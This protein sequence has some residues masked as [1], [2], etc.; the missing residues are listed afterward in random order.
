MKLRGLV[1]DDSALYRRILE[2]SLASLP[3][4]EIL[5]SAWNGRMALEK[6]RALQPDFVTLDID[7]PEMDG[8]G[9]L[10]SVR[11]GKMAVEAIIVSGMSRRSSESTVRALNRGALDFVVKP[12]EDSPEKNRER[13]KAALA[14]LVRAIGHRVEVRGLLGKTSRAQAPDVYEERAH[15]HSPGTRSSLVRPPGLVLIGVSTGGPVALAQLLRGLP[16]RLGVPILVV[17]H[18]PP[19]FTQVLAADLNTRTGLTVK[20][21]TD[22]DVAQPDAVYLAPGGNHM[23][24]RRSADGACVLQI[25]QDPPVNN[26]RPA[27][28]YLF[29]SAAQQFP[30]ECLAVILTGMGSDGTEGVRAVKE[31]GG[32][33]IAQD[34]ASCVV[35]GMPK[36]VIDAGLADAVAPLDR[37]AGMIHAMVAKGRL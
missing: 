2:Q 25:T 15:T 18:M 17:Q 37:I 16:H 23:R 8:F 12:D 14:P 7:M 1:V 13:L 26:C 31:R 10:E 32:C 24:V 29:R 34:E 20:E 19:M 22:G 27:V 5:G 28:D 4:V 6:L 30:G 9:V 11:A 36:S 33:A 35:Y 3:D 21:A